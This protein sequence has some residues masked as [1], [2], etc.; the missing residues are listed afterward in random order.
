MN[1][2]TIDLDAEVFDVILV[3]IAK[4]LTRP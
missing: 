3:T 2:V 4:A 1:M